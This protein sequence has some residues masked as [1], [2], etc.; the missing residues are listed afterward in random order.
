MRGSCK[1]TDPDSKQAGMK[2]KTS[3]QVMAVLQTRTRVGGGK[4]EN[5]SYR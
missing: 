4:P 2:S 3:T 5:L 1:N